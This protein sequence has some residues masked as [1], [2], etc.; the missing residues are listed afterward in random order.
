[1]P[2]A[3]YSRKARK[4]FPGFLL[5]VIIA[6]LFG[7]VGLAFA[8]GP[9][10]EYTCVDQQEFDADDPNHGG[11]LP[12]NGGDGLGDTELGWLAR[13]S[14][15][16]FWW[17]T[18]ANGVLTVKA[19][20]Q[21]TNTRFNKTV[22]VQPGVNYR[23]VMKVA[24]DFASVGSGITVRATP[25][26]GT[27]FQLGNVDASD[28][29]ITFIT[30]HNFN[31][32]SPSDV[33]FEISD[34]I[35][36]ARTLYFDFIWI[37]ESNIALPTPGPGTPTATTVPDS[38]TPIPTSTPYCVT[39]TATPTP[40]APQFELTPTATPTP[41]AKPFRVVDNFDGQTLV[42]FWRVAGNGVYVSTSTGRAD[43]EPG[44]V[45]IPYSVPP[46]G[47]DHTAMLRTALIGDPRVV[48]AFENF[49]TPISGTVYVDGWGRTDFMP[50]GMSAYVEV[51]TLNSDTHEWSSA[52][53]AQVSTGSWYN[54]HI[55]ITATD[56]IDAIAFLSNRSD[57]ATSG[58]VYLDDLDIYQD[59]SFAPNCSG[60]F[61]HTTSGSG[62]P[63]V[64]PIDKPCP[65]DLKVPNNFWGPLL[66]SLTLVGDQ[67]F[68]LT[69]LHVRLEMADKVRGFISSPIFFYVGLLAALF[70]LRIPIG[71]IGVVIAM[72]V[73][74]SIYNAWLLIKEA[75][76]FL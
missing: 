21:N 10:G 65:P 40:G 35:Q 30:P 59:L 74:L 1:M 71:C 11:W 50:E 44:A 48:A 68:A 12:S 2:T 14:F 70:D 46:G 47:W 16:L 69:P 28:G 72:N 24:S 52:D 17:A 64:F 51:W 55:E 37:V 32:T 3:S 7:F 22:H 5:L 63:I 19:V 43:S 57:G 9:C 73:A 67:L 34:N 41:I 76:P 49:T 58:G 61:F 4:L 45:F 20:G 25:P 18:S 15:G 60:F 62:T 26:G 13:K 29:F 36:A 53:T 42:D 6:N 56:G 31:I 54:F 75:I 33:N 38:A 27:T 8:T 23:V 66:A 39:S